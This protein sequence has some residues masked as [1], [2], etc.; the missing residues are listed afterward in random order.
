MPCTRPP[1]RQLQAIDLLTKKVVWR[2]PIGTTRDMG[3]L[4]FR[5]PSGLPTDVFSMGGSVATQSGLIFVV[6]TTD[7]YIRAFDGRIGN[8]SGSLICRPAETPRH[9]PIW[10]PMKDKM[11][12]LPP[13]EM[14]ACNRAIAMTSSRLSCRGNSCAGGQRDGRLGIALTSFFRD[15]AG[16]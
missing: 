4:G 11:S 13:A 1:W 14:A 9:S 8:F 15:R 6:A 2:R 5:L 16:T 12:L 10:G 3:P 7:Q